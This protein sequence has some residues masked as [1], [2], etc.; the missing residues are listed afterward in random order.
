MAVEAAAMAT[1]TV[2]E[3]EME[4]A[5][6]LLLEVEAVIEALKSWTLVL[7]TSPNITVSHASSSD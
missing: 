5:M 4:M 2:T 6:E 7:K 1:A 3:T